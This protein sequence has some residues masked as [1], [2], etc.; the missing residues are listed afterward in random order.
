[1]SFEGVVAI[2]ICFAITYIAIVLA[3]DKGEK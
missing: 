3:E 2:G 1:M